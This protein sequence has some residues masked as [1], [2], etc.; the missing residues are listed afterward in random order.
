MVNR[1]LVPPLVVLDIDKALAVNQYSLVS[2]F[3]IIGIT[4]VIAV[5]SKEWFFDF[6]RKQDYTI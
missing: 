3:L 6:L 1:N 4:I 5:S 2:G